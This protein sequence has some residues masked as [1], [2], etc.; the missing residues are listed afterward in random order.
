M[1]LQDFKKFI[2]SFIVDHN[3]M[4]FEDKRVDDTKYQF[5]VTVQSIKEYYC[6][7]TMKH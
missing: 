6:L 1:T 4:N 2:G 3:E 5:M 7:K